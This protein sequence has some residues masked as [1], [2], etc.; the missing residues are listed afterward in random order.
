MQSSQNLLQFFTWLFK[1]TF[2]FNLVNTIKMDLEISHCL[3][4]ICWRK[5]SAHGCLTYLFVKLIVKS[6]I[7]YWASEVFAPFSISCSSEGTFIFSGKFFTI[8]IY[9][10][11]YIIDCKLYIQYIFIYIHIYYILY[12]LY[13]CTSYN[14]Y[15][16]IYYIY[17]YI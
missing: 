15:I 3:S 10:Y 9:I 13:I 12:V 6:A 16:Y 8:Y 17:I 1:S 5:Y 4:C 2:Q 11:I 7:I 14:I